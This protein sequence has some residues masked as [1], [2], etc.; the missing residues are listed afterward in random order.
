MRTD[1][2]GQPILNENDLCS[3]FLQDPTRVIKHAFVE[4]NIN[5][6]DSIVNTE[7]LPNLEKY[8]DIGISVKEFDEI[9][10]SN[11]HMPES[12]KTF[13]IAKYVLDKCKTEEELQRVGDELL[14]FQERGMFVL[15]QYLKFLVDTMRENKVVWGVGR[16]SSVASYVL[17]L[18]GVHRINSLYYQLSIDEFLK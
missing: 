16:G 1:I 14:K 8:M 18:I 5:F 6:D 11:W 10:Q 13:D 7:N 4:E 2:Y 17:Y 12:Y 9:N 15:L 3:L